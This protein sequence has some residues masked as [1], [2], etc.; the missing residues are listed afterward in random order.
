LCGGALGCVCGGGGGGEGEITQQA[1]GGMQV[2][3]GLARVRV[4]GGGM[5]LLGEERKRCSANSGSVR[6]ILRWR[7]I[8]HTESSF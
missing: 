2:E 7:L 8:L 5:P 3:W 1:P 4:C 6:N